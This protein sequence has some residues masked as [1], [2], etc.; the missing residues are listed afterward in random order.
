[1]RETAR[2]ANTH[3]PETAVM[4]SKALKLA[5]AVVSAM[6]RT[7]YAETLTPAIMQP[8][9]DVAAKYG[10]IKPLNAGELIPDVA[11]P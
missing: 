5:P 10:I 7:T 4:L 9:L 8:P 11:K 1:M 2:W 6:S 3:H